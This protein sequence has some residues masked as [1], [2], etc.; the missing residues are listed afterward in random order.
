[1][2]QKILFISAT[3]GG[4][5]AERA[6]LNIIN[7]LRRP[8]YQPHLALFQ[9]KGVFLDQ[10]A[11][12]VPVHELQPEAAHFLRQ[13]WVRI[14]ALQHLCHQIQPDLVMSFLWQVNVVT[15]FTD[16]LFGCGCPIVVNEQVALQRELAAR[17]QRH[18]FWPLAR[19]LYRRAGWVVTIS[20]GIAAELQAKLQLPADRFRVIHNPIVWP[21]VFA[22]AQPEAGQR[23]F[24]LIAIG[25]LT[26]QKN[27][28]LLLQAVALV[29]R[30]FSL[31][32]TIL[33]EG[34]Q[35]SFLAQMVRDLHLESIVTLPGFQANP[36]DWLARADLFVLTSDY[37]GFANVIVEAM[38]V[39]LPV[40]ATDCPYGP[41][42]ILQNG[43]Y[44]L[45]VPTG[46]ATALAEAII[47]LLT[48]AERRHALG[49]MGQMRAADFRVEQI[50]PQYEAL[51]ANLLAG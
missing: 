39:G 18:L 43:R 23:P 51:F 26:P 13:N 16:W 37:E 31:Q 15:L 45:L 25:R 49:R 9:R 14:R 8:A 29:Q 12:D 6:A 47:A 7:Q 10:L 34:E 40:I 27:F 50:V 32:V 11:S 24:H 30:Q 5:G 42:E 1:M 35:R 44:G 19:F 22:S 41:A 21:T 17:W 20:Q 46:D 48:D 2:T 36:Q 28:P 3:M 38:A 4:G 33:G